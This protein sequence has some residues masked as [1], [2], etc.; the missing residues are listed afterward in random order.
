MKLLILALILFCA[1]IALPANLLK[2]SDFSAKDNYMQHWALTTM[3]DQV[4][5]LSYNKKGKFVELESTGTEYSGYINQ[6]VRV[7]P[8][9][10][11]LFRV[12]IRHIK[13]RLFLWMVGYDDKRQPVGFQKYRWLSSSVGHPLVPNFVPQ[14]YVQGSNKVEWKIEELELKTTKPKK[15]KKEVAFIK[16]N[17]GVYFSTGKFQVRKIEFIELDNNKAKKKK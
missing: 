7:K 5:D 6:F 11:Y 8:N 3:S 2:N 15:S 12:N 4:F 10:K 16:V 13:G 14:K 17:V 9:T 1:V